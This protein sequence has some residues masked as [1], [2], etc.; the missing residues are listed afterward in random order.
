MGYEVA[1]TNFAYLVDKDDSSL[2][3]S[4]EEAD[5]RA[6][7]NWQRAANQ[8]YPYARVKLGDYNYY[9]LGTPID[10]NAAANHYKIAAERHQNAQAMFNLGY[11]HEKGL[12][13][14]KAVVFNNLAY[15]KKKFRTCI[16]PNVSMTWL[17]RRTPMLLF[18][19]RWPY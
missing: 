13:V 10:Y 19:L 3:D 17:P 6:L 15:L 11:M 5:K 12:G 16:W 8:D 14:N 1:Q 2:F 18:Q 9:G 4:K 7:V